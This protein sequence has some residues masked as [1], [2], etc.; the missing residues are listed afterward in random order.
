MTPTPQKQRLLSL[1]V[2]RGITIG[3]MIL[4]NNPGSW[5]SIYAPLRHADWIGMTPTD[6]IYPFFMFIMGVSMFF[7]LGR[8][9]DGLRGGIF[10]RIL[11]RSA[12]IFALGL[13]LQWCSY[14]GQGLS[15]SLTGRIAEGESVW[16]MIFPL[17]R[18]RIMGVF[19]GLALAY[20][21]GATLCVALRW[22][23][24][25]ILWIAGAI[26]L[27]YIVLLHVGHGY[28]LG[29]HNILAV[30]DRAVLGEPHLYRQALL[31]GT[32]IGFEPEGLL[33]SL[34]RTV[35]VALGA[36]VGWLIVGRKEKTES[37]S[38]IFIF[39]TIVLLAGLLLQYGDPLNKKIWSASFTLTSC[40][41]A[42][43]ALALLLWII[44]IRGSRSWSRPFEVFGVNPLFLYCVGWL[45]SVV[46]N[47]GFLWNEGTASLKGLLC[48]EV[49]TPLL[50]DYGGS[51]ACALA[52][53]ATVWMTGYVLYRKKIYIKL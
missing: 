44:D 31:D 20:L 4:V 10:L 52:I 40:G 19:Q 14:I 45:L 36:F 46:L 49:L 1:D 7:S 23:W 34:P 9:D 33:S 22:H 38:A 2:M 8:F 24:R 35:H 25:R 42:S 21:F 47:F 27:F 29:E 43:M 15:A 11:K 16:S 6:L 50:G 51:L 28:E 41:L 53:V 26:L 17:G 32:R 13:A 30:V 12:A 39:G 18:F 5:S 37:M 3:A 48:G